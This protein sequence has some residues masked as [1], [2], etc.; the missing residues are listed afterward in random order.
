MSI[1]VVF[2]IIY[3]AHS[4]DIGPSSGSIPYLEPTNKAFLTLTAQ[5]AVDFIM[6]AKILFVIAQELRSTQY[7]YSLRKQ[8]L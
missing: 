3:V 4:L 2:P 8:G 5:Q 1:I 7:H 6:V